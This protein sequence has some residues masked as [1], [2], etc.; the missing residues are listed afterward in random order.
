M[1][2]ECIFCQIAAGAIPSDVVGE[3]DNVLA[4]RDI[5]PAAPVHVLLIPKAHVADSAADLTRADGPLLGELFELAAGIASES[6]LDDG[7][8]LVTNVGAAAG[9]TVFHLHFH[10]LGGWNRDAGAPRLAEES[11]G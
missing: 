10:L 3:S 1:N 6:D 9:Q 7:W 11:G 2:S 8:R 4:F 5:N